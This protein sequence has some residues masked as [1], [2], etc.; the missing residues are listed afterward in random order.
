MT[1][2]DVKATLDSI[3]GKTKDWE[4]AHSMEDALFADVLRA[5]AKGKCSD[6][7]A[8]AKAALKS[9]DID[10]KREGA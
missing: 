8:I 9:L 7:K 1:V 3:R 4:A 5:I 2:D 10:F 6:P